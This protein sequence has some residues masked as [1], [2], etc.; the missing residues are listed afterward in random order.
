MLPGQDANFACDGDHPNAKVCRFATEAAAKFVIKIT[1][2]PTGGNLA[3]S[4]LSNNFLPFCRK[5]FS[6]EEIWNMQNNP[7]D[8]K[9]PCNIYK[10]SS[11]SIF[12]T[13]SIIYVN[14]L[15][16]EADATNAHCDKNL[17]YR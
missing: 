12:N 8:L 7:L 2:D 4:S 6:M 16:W 17:L 10:I 5:Y 9:I 13:N 15:I 11:I 14:L 1:K 3:L